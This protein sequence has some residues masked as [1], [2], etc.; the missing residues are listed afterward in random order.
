MPA[1]TQLI[2]NFLGGV[3]RQNDDKKLVNQLTEC[4][5]GYPDATFGLLKRP[6]MKFIDRLEETNGAV[7]TESDLTDA[8]WFYI[9]RATAG[10]YVGCIKGTS[11]RVWNA[12]TGE[13]CTVTAPGGGAIATGY[14]TGTSQNDYHFRSI[15][16]TTIITNK[17]V[18]TAMQADST[19]VANSVGTLKL[20][21]IDTFPYVVTLQGD[22][23]SVTPQSTETFDDMLLFDI[24]NINTNHHL[25]DKLRDYILARHTAGDVDFA[26]RW[27]LQGFANSLVIRYTNESNGVVTNPNTVPGGTP[28]PF[29][30]SARGGQLNDYLEFFQDDVTDIS[31]L[32]LESFDGHVIKILNSNAAE[33]DYY[34]RFSAYS[35]NGG[36]GYWEET[37]A[38][39]TSPGLDA[40]YMPHALINTTSNTFTFGPITYKER[41]TG[42]DVTN[43]DPSFIGK[44][45]SSTFFYS[46]RF[47]VLSGDD[48][49]LGVANDP[50]NF[51]ARSALT[52]VDS[53][54]IDLNVSSVRPVTLSDVLPSPQGLILFS[55][56]QQFQL[57]ATDASILTPSSAVIRALSNYEMATDISPVDIGTSSVFV[58]RV[59]GYSKLFNM[60][61]R[62]VEQSPLVVDISKAVLEW[63][64]DSIDGLSVSPPNS[65]VIL[66]DRDSSYLYV[67]RYYNNGEQDLF[68]SWTK[69]ELPGTIQAAKIINDEVYVVSQHED[70]YTIGSIALDELPAGSTVSTTTGFSG[71]PALDMATRPV[72]P[73]GGTT[74]PV[75]YDETNDITKVYIPYTP[76]ANREAA[77]LLTVP[78]GANVLASDQGYW[79]SA[80]ERT[81]IGTGYRYFEV[82][83]DFSNYTDGIVI[84][85]NYD[86][87]VTLPKF[88]FRRDEATT[89]YTA[90]LTINKVQLSAGRT[91]AIQFKL[92]PTGSNEWR[93][94]EHIT[95]AGVYDNDTNP[96]VGER[97]FSVPIHQRNTNFELKVTSNYPY[98]VSLVSMMWEG[99]YSPRFY[100]RT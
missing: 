50:Y 40:S 87:E 57:Y 69:W 6:G 76:I 3:S 35:G 12:E 9:D 97:V 86:L 11:I 66:V 60:Q 51:F 26:G 84:G 82:K 68:Q 25:I 91:G 77:M 2:P 16:D 63:L 42:D 13:A 14:L 44:P 43:A 36:A 31:K 37:R 41:L 90:T 96:V 45:I 72:S 78:D 94:I 49:I 58:S 34:V 46:N 95:L 65:A 8:A 39:D 28:K 70:E 1:V 48:V 24:N 47:G 7:L 67:Y 53:D 99:M 32:P 21:Q 59:P 89:D 18:N 73:D 52:Q 83:G 5:N 55:E 100:R 64:P 15:Q 54:P 93:N 71:N 79:A 81:E 10:S 27:Y 61:L 85:Y 74:D 56:R 22:K 38:P 88:Y 23:I 33:D 92:K 4:V 19:F 80:A 29:T 75:V 62:D 17:T 30:L 20:L 98:P